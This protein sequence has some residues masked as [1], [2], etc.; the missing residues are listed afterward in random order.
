VFGRI[1]DA[2]RA[3]TGLHIAYVTS[4]F[5]HFITRCGDEHWK[6]LKR[7]IRYL[8]G[9]VNHCALFRRVDEIS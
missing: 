6:A 1:L 3:C 9:T 8:K 2:S 4:I 5:S 7:V